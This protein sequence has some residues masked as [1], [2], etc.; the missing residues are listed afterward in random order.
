MGKEAMISFEGVVVSS[1][2]D[3]EI[4]AAGLTAGG[5]GSIEDALTCW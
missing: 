3:A 4:L 5:V 1:T 2:T